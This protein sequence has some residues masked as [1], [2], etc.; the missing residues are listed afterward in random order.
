LA[1]VEEEG[2]WWRRW[3][4]HLCLRCPDGNAGWLERQ[5]RQFASHQAQLASDEELPSVVREQQRLAD[6][7]QVAFRVRRDDQSWILTGEEEALRRII[8]IV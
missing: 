5:W 4:N 6:L 7:G 2:R 3:R 8:I 1:A